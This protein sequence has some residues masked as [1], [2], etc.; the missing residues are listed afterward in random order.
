MI[1]LIPAYE[2]DEKLLPLVQ[3]L[4]ERNYT[5]VVVDDGSSQAAQAVFAQLPAEVILLRH[6]ENRGKGRAI[7]TACQYIAAHFPPQEGVVTVDADGQHLPADIDAVCQAWRQTP[8]ALVLG[9]R[10][11]TGKVPIRNRFGNA[12]TRFIFRVATGVPVYDT[13]TGLRAFSVSRIP[14][15]LEMQG[16]R[17]EYEINVLLYATRRK[18]PIREVEISTV[19]LDGNQ[20]SH[21]NPLRDAW[22]IYKM[23]LLFAASSLVAAGVD[24]GLVLLFSHL[25]RGAAHWLLYSVVLARVMSSVLNYCLNREVVFEDCSKRS[26]LRYYLVAAGILAANY[27]LLAML[28]GLMPLAI[29]KLIV[30]AVLY[31]ASFLLQRKYVFTAQVS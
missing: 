8:D 14:M 19:Y 22:R 11:F 5:L 1:A 13:Q 30:E 9:S 4:V 28:E 29:S 15:M 20:T 12:V 24:Y 27:G 31:P 26:V 18:I 21:F 3:S 23:I 6:T 17:Y 16:E 10:Q 7:K 25:F 2:P